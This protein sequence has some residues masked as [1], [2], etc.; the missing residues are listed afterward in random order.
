MNLLNSQNGKFKVPRRW[1]NTELKKIGP[2]F[3]GEM[4]NVSG[5]D[6]RDKQGGSYKSYFTGCSAYY[7]SNFA[8]TR[9]LSDAGAVTNFE[10]DL[11]KD[12]NRELVNRFDV[13]FNHTTLEHVFDVFKAFENLCLMSRDIVIIV[14]PFTQQI[15]TSD[16]FSDYWRFTP[17]AIKKL[18]ERNGLTVIYEAA[19]NDS[20]CSNYVLSVGSRNP[21]NWKNK[22]EYHEVKSL[23]DWIAEPAAPVKFIKSLFSNS[24]KSGE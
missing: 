13:V 14:L 17:M 19:N 9:G 8:G 21:Q 24:S 15:H 11:E 6:D 4:I 2:V 23:S 12:L 20:D 16:S 22:L 1:S 10:I 7:I 5:W 18:F 3:K